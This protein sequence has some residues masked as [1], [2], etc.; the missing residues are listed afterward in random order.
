MARNTT[1]PEGDPV[2]ADEPQTPGT[3][4]DEPAPEEMTVSEL[5]AEADRRGV[6]SVEGSGK[7]GAVTKA[8]LIE[9]VSE[10]PPPPVGR[11]PLIDVAEASAATLNPTPVED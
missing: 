9:V 11:P 3:P 10:V 4:T 2:V 5:R 7:G 6:D 8:D 1:P